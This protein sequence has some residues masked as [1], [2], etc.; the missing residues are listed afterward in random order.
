LSAVD[1]VVGSDTWRFRCLDFGVYQPNEKFAMM[2]DLIYD[3]YDNGADTDSF[4]Y[5]YSVGARPT[6]YFDKNWSI[7]FE[8]GYDYTIGEGQAD[9]GGDLKGSVTKFTLAP[10]L[11]LDNIFMARPVLRAFVTYA[12][13]SKDFENIVGDVA[14]ANETDGLNFGLQVEAWF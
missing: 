9:D 11:A 2:Y 7:A 13:W 6:Y 14:H 8:A 10:Q 3:C 5:W 4:T 1:D 12:F